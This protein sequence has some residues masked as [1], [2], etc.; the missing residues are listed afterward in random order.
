MVTTYQ[1]RSHSKSCRKYKNEK[2]RYHFGKFFTEPTI[3]SLPSPSDLPEAGKN[4]IL[5][6]RTIKQYNS[7]DPRER[8]TLNP[9]KEDFEKTPSIKNI[10]A[11]LGFTEDQY[12]NALSISSD[13][14]FHIHS[15]EH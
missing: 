2:Y 5:N 13:S 8:N 6:E 15:N 12:Y 9:L 7:L 14:D 4:N 3:I 10:L 11:Q 1:V